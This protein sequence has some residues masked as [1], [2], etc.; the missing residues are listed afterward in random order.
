MKCCAYSFQAGTFR[1]AFGIGYNQRFPSG[2][3]SKYQIAGKGSGL[4]GAGGTVNGNIPVHS[5]I[6]R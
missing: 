6:L 4:H 5:C 1:T 2:N 3:A